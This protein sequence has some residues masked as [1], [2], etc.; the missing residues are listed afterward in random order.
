MEW[1]NYHQLLLSSK[2]VDDDDWLEEGVLYS[3]YAR[4]G[5]GERERE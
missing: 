2:V 3:V 5:V 1:L 4:E